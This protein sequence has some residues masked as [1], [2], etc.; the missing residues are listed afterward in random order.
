MTVMLGS[1]FVGASMHPLLT[2]WVSWI[3][4]QEYTWAN[5]YRILAGRG[6]SLACND[7]F[8]AA[9]AA[10]HVIGTLGPIGLRATSLYD[11]TPHEAGTSDQA[12]DI[13]R[14]INALTSATW[15]G[16]DWDAEGARTR[17]D[18]EI[19]LCW[20]A[21]VTG[22]AIAIRVTKNGRSRWRMI[23]ATRVANPTGQPND[24]K[25]RDGFTLD[26]D[27][28]I[29][30]I[31]VHKGNV[32]AFG[33]AVQR[34]AV[35]IP[36]IADDGTPNVIHRVGQ[37]LEGMIRGVTRL[38]PMIILSRQLNG[39]LESHVAAKRLQAIHGMVV[40]AENPEEYQQALATG[41]ALNPYN[42]TVKGPLNVW[43]K[44]EGQQVDFPSTE[45]KGDDLAAYLTLMYKVQCAAVQYP[46][47]VVLCQMGN[48]SL[49]SA[50]AG[51]DQFDRTNQGEQ[52][53]HIA[54]CS[55]LMDRAAVADAIARGELEL[56][57][58]EWSQVMAGKYARPPKYSTDRKKDA[59]TIAALMAAGVSGPTAF[60][61]FGLN[62]EDEQELRAACKVFLAAQGITDATE[63]P[64]Q[65]P[66]V[67]GAPTPAT[68]PTTSGTPDPQADPQPDP[69]QGGPN[70]EEPAAK[71][72]WYRRVLA[73]FRP[74]RE[75]A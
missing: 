74:T 9:L 39:V 46:V 50:R 75:A 41:D 64:L 17:L 10:A 72:P 16:Y 19:L 23:E 2:D 51:L 36:W 37:R 55:S 12:R 69:G 4:T 40:E 20:T 18:L 29:D 25:L 68:A 11:D 45:F 8:I 52:E 14:R 15:Y 38:A 48:A 58:A 66:P 32:G 67:A 54:E 13:R 33:V 60:E 24:D 22:E 35:W 27:G 7:P 56:Q 49:S 31:W 6:L 59:E 44:R 65:A 57:S 73:R 21:F 62:W 5:E 28:R 53:K 63:K 26:A 30:G 47:D 42:F 43:V 1:Q 71:V 70:D 3:R 34:E 61:M